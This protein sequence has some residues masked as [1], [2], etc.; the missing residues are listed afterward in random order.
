MNY[1]NYIQVTAIVTPPQ[2]WSD[3]RGFVGAGRGA[4]RPAR[5]L[6]GAISLATVESR[7][8]QPRRDELAQTLQAEARLIEKRLATGVGPQL[9]NEGNER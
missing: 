1:T 8:K 2:P 7:M 3:L 6:V 4:S 5:Q 9:Q